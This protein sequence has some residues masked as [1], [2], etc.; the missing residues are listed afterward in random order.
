[1]GKT[2]TILIRETKSR[3]IE[4]QVNP[5]DCTVSDYVN[6]I[7]ENVDRLGDVNLPGKRGLKGIRVSTFLPGKGS[8]FG[9]DRIKGDLKLVERW[10]KNGTRLRIVTTNPTLNFKALID[11]DSVTLKEGQD[12]VY[13][14]WSFTEYKDLQVPG[15][16]SVEGMIRVGD[17]VL[18][19][20]AE[21]E[22]PAPGTTVTVASGTTLW[23]L[24]VKYYG[25]GTQWGKI[26][27]AN[28]NI[29]PKKL[30]KGM[31]LTIP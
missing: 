22:A 14:D 13:I 19:E 4:L 8:P 24:A 12:D 28:G 18:Q 20:R 21:G 25:D 5:A 30:Q 10:K 27:A 9:S 6:N 16:E 23:G 11:S 7:K 3:S 31:A 29:D 26:A 15:V 2:R 1:M 17:P